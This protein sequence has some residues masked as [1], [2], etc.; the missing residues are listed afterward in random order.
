MASLKIKEL[1]AR[2]I[3]NSRGVPTLEVRLTTSSGKTVV[4]GVPA[5]AS[6]GKREALDLRDKDSK[7]FSGKGVLKAVQNVNHVIAPVLKKKTFKD[8]KA[9]DAV[10]LTLDSSKQ[11][12][13]L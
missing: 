8:I 13:K 11:K 3:L 1:H 4:A 10:L 7:R 5:G 6:T 2:E 9:F 12:S